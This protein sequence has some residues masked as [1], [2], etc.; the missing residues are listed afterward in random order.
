M[1][2]CCQSAALPPLAT[3]AKTAQGFKDARHLT[4]YL[5]QQLRTDHQ[6]QAASRSYKIIHDG[7]R[8]LQ[9]SVV[10]KR[11]IQLIADSA[12]HFSVKL[13]L[14]I[15][16]LA[17]CSGSPPQCSTFS[18]TNIIVANV[19]GLTMCGEFSSGNRAIVVCSG[20]VGLSFSSMVDFKIDSLAFTSCR[21]E[22]GPVTPPSLPSFLTAN[23]VHAA[24]LL[25]STLN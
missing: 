2:G 16:M 1:L 17:A 6:R 4:S 14:F 3:V 24:L 5:S 23:N 18:S 12:N 21:G 9:V 7:L 11:P 10:H 22:Y 8:S 20:S 13:S 25:Q 15:C 19:A